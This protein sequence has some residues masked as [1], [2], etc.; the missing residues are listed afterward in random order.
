MNENNYY[1]YVYIDPRDYTEF[2]YG[3]GIKNRKD[4]HLNDES[5]TEKVKIIKEIIS[6]GM[7]PIIKV[8]ARNLTEDQAFLVEKT[9]I[10]KLGKNLANISSGH[11]AENFR[12]PKSLHKDI[13]G[14]D[15]NNGIYFFNCGDDGKNNRKWE[16]FKNF[17]F[18]TAGGGPKYSDA[19]RSFEI[20]DIAC[21]YLSKFGYVGVAKI[22]TKAVISTL[23]KIN[24]RSLDEIGLGHYVKWHSGIEDKEY[25]CE[26]EWLS[27]VEKEKAFFQ[28]KSNIFS[29]IS[30]KASMQYQVETVQKISE[31]FNIDIKSLLK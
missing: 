24:N 2:Y 17:N 11:Y 19:I 7:K 29:P 4:S 22:K 28:K 15:Y 10:W 3:K 14:F 27:V 20:G 31:Y 8:V 1:V 12:P 26:V 18:I 23:F 13:W 25:M 21:V 6:E 16:D 9:L 30:V 5:D